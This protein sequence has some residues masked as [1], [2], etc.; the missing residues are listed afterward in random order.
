[1]AVDFNRLFSQQTIMTHEV[2]LEGGFWDFLEC[3]PGVLLDYT[4]PDSRQQ[5]TGEGKSTGTER[6]RQVITTCS[7]GMRF[8]PKPQPKVPGT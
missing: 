8:P 5:K 1:M 4:T 3:R 2:T 6:G 7:M